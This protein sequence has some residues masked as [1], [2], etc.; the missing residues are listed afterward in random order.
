MA[1]GKSAAK[2]VTVT[3][4]TINGFFSDYAKQMVEE[5]EAKTGNKVKI[6][7]IDYAQLYEKTGD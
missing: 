5:Y 2:G 7:K 6:I 4:A 3:W 1:P